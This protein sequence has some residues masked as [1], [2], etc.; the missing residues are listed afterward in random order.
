MVFFFV[1]FLFGRPTKSI[2]FD[3]PAQM[4]LKYQRPGK[5]V[6]LSQTQPR[7]L[8]SLFGINLVSRDR[9]VSSPEHVSQLLSCVLRRGWCRFSGSLGG[10]SWSSRWLWT[11]ERICACVVCVC[12]LLRPSQWRHKIGRGLSQTRTADCLLQQSLH[13]CFFCD[14]RVVVVVVVVCVLL[15]EDPTWVRASRFFFFCCCCFFVFSLV[16]KFLQ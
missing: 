4:S 3:F 15:L 11:C 6:L 7:R 13:F 5:E 2:L 14:S 9:A 8:A 12:A 1:C 10:E 16:G